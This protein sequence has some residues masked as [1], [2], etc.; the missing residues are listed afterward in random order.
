[1]YRFLSAR[2]SV[3]SIELSFVRI[4]AVRT[5]PSE[6][7]VRNVLNE[8]LGASFELAIRREAKNASTSTIRIGKAALLKNRLMGSTLPVV[9]ARVCG[10]YGPLSSYGG[11]LEAEQCGPAA[12]VTD[13]AATYGRLRKRSA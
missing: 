7:C 3:T 13:N 8:V 5:C 4:V 1:M 6:S 10:V 2:S 11:G 9:R 12:Y